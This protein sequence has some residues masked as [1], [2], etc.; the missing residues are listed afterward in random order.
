MLHLSGIAMYSQKKAQPVTSE[1]RYVY[2]RWPRPAA[3]TGLL[4][5]SLSLSS[6]QLHA[7]YTAACSRQRQVLL[8]KCRSV[9]IFHFHGPSHRCGGHCAKSLFSPHNR[10]ALQ[11]CEENCRVLVLQMPQKDKGWHSQSCIVAVLTI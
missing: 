7:S 1:G 2:N 9:M 4:R 8:I 11:S 10:A 6:F 5:A 3:L